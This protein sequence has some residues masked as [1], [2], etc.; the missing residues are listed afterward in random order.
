MKDFRNAYFMGVQ[1]TGLF[2]QFVHCFWACK[3]V[4]ETVSS[5][6]HSADKP[7]DSQKVSSIVHSADKPADSQRV[8]P[9]SAQEGTETEN[10]HLTAWPDLAP[11]GT[12]TPGLYQCA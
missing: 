5:I 12:G 11:G 3:V 7:A 8:E 10:L 1:L 4:L 2:E 6:V 9:G